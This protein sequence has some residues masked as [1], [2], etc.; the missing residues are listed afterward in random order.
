MAWVLE[1]FLLVLM[2][3]NVGGNVIESVFWLV[4]E[5]RSCDAHVSCSEHL[6]WNLFEESS[7][8]GYL[9]SGELCWHSKCSIPQV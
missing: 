4:K 8:S 9:D 1:H 7:R 2:V 6:A 5:Y 3:V